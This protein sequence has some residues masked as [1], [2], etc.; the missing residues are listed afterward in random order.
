MDQVI[1]FAFPKTGS[2]II[3]TI[4][5]MFNVFLY[6]FL[7]PNGWHGYVRAL[8]RCAVRSACREG[9]DRSIWLEFGENCLSFN[10]SAIIIFLAI[11]GL[12]PDE[13]YFQWCLSLEYTILLIFFHY[14]I[15]SSVCHD[16]CNFRVATVIFFVHLLSLSVFNIFLLQFLFRR[17]GLLFCSWYVYILFYSLVCFIPVHFMFPFLLNG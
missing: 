13:S 3:I 6:F 5:L 9:D 2:L 1:L 16:V 4:C 15:L 8:H 7:Q 14:F 17:L 11:N 10:L 12:L